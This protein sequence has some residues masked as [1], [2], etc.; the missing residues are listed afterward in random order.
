MSLETLSWRD[1]E[2]RSALTRVRT[3]QPLTYGLTNYIAAH[4]S[5][6]M[7][8]AV[9]ASPAIGAITYAAEHL[10]SIAGGVWI[11]LAALITD[12]PDQL[13]SVASAAR[14]AGTPWVLDPVVVGAGSA[15]IDGF[16]RELLALGPAVVRG[17]AS[18]IIGLAGGD[19]QTKGVD[20]TATPEEALGLAIELARSSGAVVAVSGAADLITD[21]T[22]SALIP[23]GHPLL[24]RVTATGCG[25]GALV[26]A[27]LGAGLDPFD[28]AVGAHSALAEAAERAGRRAR[29]TGTFVVALLDELSLL[30]A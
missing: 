25:L 1:D 7:V 6:N 20:S 24:T 21:G 10:A 5:A 22:R 28:A 9:G 17:N 16:A 30:E 11:N 26:A 3:V 12:T 14:S 15:E 19:A 18:E 13:T 27:Y 8:L 29:G 23:G 4:Q 2:A